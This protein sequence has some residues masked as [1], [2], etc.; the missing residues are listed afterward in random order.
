MKY[1]LLIIICL[2]IISLFLIIKTLS[3]CT[4]GGAVGNYTLKSNVLIWK[5][6]DWNGAQNN[7]Y[8][9]WMNLPYYDAGGTYQFIGVRNHPSSSLLPW[10]GF[11]NAGLCIVNGSAHDLKANQP[12][13]NP[14]G[15]IRYNGELMRYLL[16]NCA[17]VSDVEQ[18]LQ[19]TNNERYKTYALLVVGDANAQAAIFEVGPTTFKRD[20]LTET[21]PNINI[22]HN[23][24]TGVNEICN[25]WDVRANYCKVST[26]PA[27]TPIYSEPARNSDAWNAFSRSSSPKM[28]YKSFISD[29][30]AGANYDSSGFGIIARDIDTGLAP[31]SSIDTGYKLSR[32]E[33]VSSGVFDGVTPG[34]RYGWRLS[35]MWFCM[36][37]PSVGIFMPLFIFSGKV[38]SAVNDMYSYINVKR[39]QVYNYTTDDSTGYDTGR[40]I[41]KTIDV[42]TLVGNGNSYGQGGIQQYIFSIE[43]WEYLI[44]DNKMN[45]I[46]NGAYRYLGDLKN[47][48]TY[49]QNFICTNAKKN[50]INEKIWTNETINPSVISNYPPNGVTIQT[51]QGPGANITLKFSED[52][53]NTAL[54]PV[55]NYISIKG[56]LGSIN[57]NQDN[58]HYKVVNGQ[59]VLTISNIFFNGETITVSIKTNVRDLVGNPCASYTYQ[60]YI[61]SGP[62]ITRHVVIN[63][64]STFGNNEYQEYIELYNFST[65]AV[66]ITSYSL[67]QGTLGGITFPTPITIQA[68]EKYLIAENAEAFYERYKFFPDYEYSPSAGGY[69]DNTEVP[70]MVLTGTFNLSAAADDQQSV[71][72]FTNTGVPICRDIVTWDTTGGGLA[73]ATLPSGYTGS[74]LWSG[75]RAAPMPGAGNDRAIERRTD[76]YEAIETNIDTIGNEENDEDCSVTFRALSVPDPEGHAQGDGTGSATLTPLTAGQGTTNIL[77]FVIYPEN[78]TLSKVRVYIDTNWTWVSPAVSDVWTSAGTVT[79]NGVAPCWVTV[80]GF[81]LTM[82]HL[83]LKSEHEPAQE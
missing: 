67:H 12:S 25:G 14:S 20:N 62:A 30:R 45:D 44:Y 48:L 49:F 22:N 61:K 82:K 59:G 80:F 4:I 55:T 19:D 79:I 65:N 75:T 21:P 29:N 15:S 37:E 69:Q 51:N 18:K 7:D 26:W 33:T 43:A 76:G 52:V 47:E 63:E 72:L 73:E 31:A 3:S 39:H 60:F 42:N 13:G 27:Y 34:A 81:S 46:R 71:L 41:D 53:I 10:M 77:K 58:F 35:A 38:P 32:H 8:D 11:N 17:T 2:L 64:I 1:P 83:F 16:R 9:V 6:R 66:N 23:D 57:N 40:N 24:D 54:L 28:D 56:S 5:N 36:G 74:G 68:G 70:N 78:Y 50:Y